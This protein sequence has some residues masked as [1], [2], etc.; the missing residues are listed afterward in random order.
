MPVTGSTARPDESPSVA[1]DAADLE[2]L[3]RF[4][5]CRLPEAEW[6][7]LAHVRVAWVCLRVDEPG[8]ALA[9]IREG[10]L[11]YN[12]A[13][14]GRPHRYHDT[15]TVAFTRLIAARM[16]PG[17]RWDTFAARIDDLLDRESP[18]LLRYYSPDQLYSDEARRCFVEPDRKALPEM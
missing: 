5:G 2:F 14:L 7:H 15:V 12:T 16:S 9:R 10:I 13:V 6:T 3:A 1:V 17:E 8:V 11:R 18:A 4:E